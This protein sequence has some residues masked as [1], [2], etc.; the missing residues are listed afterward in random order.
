MTPLVLSRGQADIDKE[1]ERDGEEEVEEGVRE[2]E[3][4]EVDKEEERGEH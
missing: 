3:E 4:G 2:R 1:E